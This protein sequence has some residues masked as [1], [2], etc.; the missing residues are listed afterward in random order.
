MKI[1]KAAWKLLESPNPKGAR[2]SDIA[3]LAGVSRQALYLHFPT[4]TEML[5]AT[6]HY[7]DS[8]KDVDG[9]LEKSRK[10]RSGTER[11]DAFIEAWGNYIPEIS[12]VARVLIAM[13]TDDPDAKA[14]WNDRM[15]A[16][17]H[18]CAAAVSALDDEGRLTRH[19]SS[20]EATDILWTMLSLENW[21][22]FRE[23]CNWSQRKYLDRMTS[24]ARGLLL[25][26]NG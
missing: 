26:G 5:I 19:Y 8:V 7:I 13:S 23:N 9:R 1:L 14:A 21:I 16:V 22:H 20:S 10:A 3:K 2:M 25:R 17:R 24:M 11:L 12:G 18:G 15:Q 4:R 6:T